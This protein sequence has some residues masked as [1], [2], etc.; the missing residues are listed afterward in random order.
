MKTG[1]FLSHINKIVEQ[2]DA[3]SQEDA[4]HLLAG[5]GLECVDVDGTSIGLNCNIETLKKN[6]GESG[7]DVCSIYYPANFEWYDKTAVL[8]FKEKSKKQLEYCAY[9]GT[10][11]FMPVPNVLTK[12]SDENE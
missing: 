1:V 9:L 7:I 11:V 8:N 10:D 6:L 12:K 4:L 2:G 5:K 3:K